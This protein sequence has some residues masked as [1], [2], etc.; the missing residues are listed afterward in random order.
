MADP[1]YPRNVSELPFPGDG[2]LARIKMQP[3]SVE[4]EQSVLGSLIFRNVK[5]YRYAVA[6]AGA[7][8]EISPVV[9]VKVTPA[10]C[11][12]WQSWHRTPR[13]PRTSAP[14]PRW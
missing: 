10:A 3:H 4:A 14:T 8:L 13:V 5:P 12:T 2:E 11:P 6:T 9:E 7:P 1:E